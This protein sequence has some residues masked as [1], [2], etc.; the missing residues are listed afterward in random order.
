MAEPSLLCV[1]CARAPPPRRRTWGRCTVCV[2]RKLPS[3]YYCGEECM[4]A[5][6]PKHK[7]YQKEQK[8]RAEQVRECPAPTGRGSRCSN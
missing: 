2:E 5:H 8:R 7:V 3:T 1:N 6:W 4:N